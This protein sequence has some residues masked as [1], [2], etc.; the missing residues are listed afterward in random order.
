MAADLQEVRESDL[1][2]IAILISQ[3]FDRPVPADGATPTELPRVQTLRELMWSRVGIERDGAGLAEAARS[4][5]RWHAALGA[6]EGAGAPDRAAYELRTLV[7]CGRLAA[8][9]ALAREESR[10]AHYRADFPEPREAWRRHLVFR[11]DAAAVAPDAAAL[12]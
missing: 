7:L 9:A 10:G 6:A 5:A 2:A 11:A 1:G 12:R 3:V 8:E 4:L